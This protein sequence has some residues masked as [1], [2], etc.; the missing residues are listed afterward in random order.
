MFLDNLPLFLQYCAKP[1]YNRLKYNKV[2]NK[3]L[4]F[5]MESQWW[6]KKQIEEYQTIQLQKL[7]NHAYKNVPY[8]T[9]SF[10]DRGIKP[11]DIQT[12]EDLKK[13]PYITKKDI[14]QN[15]EQLKAKN[16]PSWKFVETS[17]GGSTGTPLKVL[18]ERG[19]TYQKEIAFQWRQ[20]K[21]LGITFTDRVAI[22]RGYEMKQKGGSNYPIFYK[23]LKY[24]NSL[25]LSSHLLEKELLLKYIQKIKKYN[26]SY[27]T[28]FPSSLYILAK[29]MFENS[30]QI[31]RVNNLI[32]SSESLYPFH[33]SLIKRAFNNATL[34]DY[35]GN[36]EATAFISHC[37]KEDLYHIIPEYGIVEIVN[38]NNEYVKIEGEKGE[39]ISTSFN[40]YAFPLIR[41]K[42]N[43][44]AI[45]TNKICSC[46][47]SHQYLKAI[48]GKIQEFIITKKRDLIP[49][50]SLNVHEDL[51]RNVDKFQYYQDEIGKVTLRIVKKSNFDNKAET[52]ISNVIQK[53]LGSNV[54]LYIE[55]VDEIPRT[56]RGKY[57]WL[58]QELDLEFGD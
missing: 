48:D 22:L 26:P 3:Q 31:S 42:T 37:A 11:K 17:T 45:W 6:S 14:Q 58:I 52:Q 28:A 54:E 46:K 56:K 25:M 21:E 32:T 23:E 49:I 12:I 38:N 1:V 9:K 10:N 24:R 53:K 50:S 15:F 39:I 18:H 2:F 41:Y 30:I 13:L 8:Y 57:C 29:F 33:R 36:S 47:K 34:L 5:L 19:V 35:Y 44:F 43:D 7:I 55:F 27:I 40:N 4:N 51:F 20:F 16:Y